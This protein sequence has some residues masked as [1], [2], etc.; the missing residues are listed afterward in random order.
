MPYK[1]WLSALPNKEP[2]LHLIQHMAETFGTSY[3]A[4]A[5]RFANLSDMPCAFVTMEGGS[6]RYAVRSTPLRRLGA[7]IGTK[8]TIPVGSLSHKLRLAGCNATDELEVAQD[9]WFDNWEKGMELWE[10]ARHYQHTDTTIALLWFNGEDFPDVEIDRFG[11]RVNDDGGLKELTGELP[12][13]GKS[14][15]R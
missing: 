13:P 5:S 1:Q 2:S 10:L 11:A 3:P 7:W 15:R 14:R 4:S 8:S 9:I 12:W 6:V